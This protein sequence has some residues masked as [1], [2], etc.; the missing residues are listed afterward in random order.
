MKVFI[1]ILFLGYLS[2]ANA[3]T[4]ITL[5]DITPSFG[6]EIIENQ[7]SYTEPGATGENQIWDFS[8]LDEISSQQ[9]I[10]SNPLDVEG[11]EYFPEATHAIG[12]NSGSG[13]EFRR[14]AN[15]KLEDLG[16]YDSGTAFAYTNYKSILEFPLQYQSTFTDTAYLMINNGNF[17]LEQTSIRSGMVDGFGTLELPSGTYTNVLRVSVTENETS[18]VFQDGEQVDNQSVNREFT[19]YYKSGYAAS[20]LSFFTFTFQ[21][22]PSSSLTY[23]ADQ[24]TSVKK[25]EDDMSNTVS[26]YPNPAENEIS[27]SLSAPKYH[28]S[29]IAIYD[30]MGQL[31]LQKSLKKNFSGESSVKIETSALSS[32]VYILNVRIGDAYVNKK[33]VIN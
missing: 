12:F 23:L 13:V 3:Q 15:N 25:I 30:L 2:I 5:D 27:I 26:I 8:T 1:S 22:S 10:F 4:I 20:L 31:V 18:L 16:A 29:S 28:V 6:T 7:G 32:G 14:Y 9:M 21:G 11:S 19:F 17:N 24:I 33:I